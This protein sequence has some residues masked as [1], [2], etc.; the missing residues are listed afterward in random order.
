MAG[1]MN[2]VNSSIA[3]AVGVLIDQEW[4]RVLMANLTVPTR[5]M[6][7][8]LPFMRAQKKGCIVNVPSETPAAELAYLA[9]KHGLVS[10]C[11]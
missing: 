10:C 2:D 8:V 5:L 1:T 7:A 3:P 9:C 4:D 11:C 6:S